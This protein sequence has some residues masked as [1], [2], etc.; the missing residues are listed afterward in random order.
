M[1]AGDSPRRRCVT[2]WQP[3]DRPSPPPAP[4]ERD[5]MDSELHC[6]GVLPIGEGEGGGWLCYGWLLLLSQRPKYFLTHYGGGDSIVQR[7]QKLVKGQRSIS[8]GRARCPSKSSYRSPLAPAVDSA[9]CGS[10]REMQSSRPSL[11][12]ASCSVMGPRV[13][14]PVEG[15]GQGFSEQNISPNNSSSGHTPIR[16]CLYTSFN[17]I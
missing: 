10:A 1:F 3:A 13:R 16:P 5:G 7:A 4:V 14:V 2:A 11:G 8:D 12:G 17:V 6:D 15:E 9:G